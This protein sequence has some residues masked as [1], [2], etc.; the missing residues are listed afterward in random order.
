MSVQQ[1]A[2]KFVDGVYEE[3]AGLNAYDASHVL[4]TIYNLNKADLRAEIQRLYAEL[5]PE[6]VVEEESNELSDF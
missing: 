2:K 4:S 6:P 1:V 3:V 5:V